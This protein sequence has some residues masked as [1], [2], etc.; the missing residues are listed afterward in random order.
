[1]SRTLI[2]SG[3]DWLGKIPINW[4][5]KPVKQ[6]LSERKELNTPITVTDILS[7]TNTRGVIPYS[8]K[9]DIG[10]KSKDDISGYKIVRKG[11]IV[12]NSMNLYIGSVGLSK[13]IGVVSPVYYMLYKRNP[14]DSIE[15]YNQLFQTKE[16]QT[17][18]HGYG[19]GILDIRMRIPMSN[20]NLLPLPVPPPE[21][22]HRIVSIL[23]NKVEQIDRLIKIQEQQIEKLKEYKQLIISN[24]VTK[25]LNIHTSLKESG[26]EWIGMI[27]THWEIR[28]L[29]SCIS[30]KLE[31]GANASGLTFDESL[32]RYIRITDITLDNELK[33]TEKLS[34]SEKDSSNYILY[35]GDV[36]FA[37]SGATVG[38][39]FLYK[40]EYGRSAYAGYLIRATVDKSV[41]S[42]EYLYYFTFSN[43][44]WEWA[45]GVFIQ[46]TIQNIG[47]NRYANMPLTV[48][49][50]D[51]QEKIVEKIKEFE[52]KI[53]LTLR[54]IKKKIEILNEY[55]KSLIYEYVTGKR[56]AI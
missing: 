35:D 12:I 15:Y 31:Y 54:L 53:K 26:I 29:K 18:S 48:P 34:L 56:E 14:K 10:N 40:K 39:S 52:S 27:P 33:D 16:L 45:K 37:R 20:L 22:Q 44:Y 17:K 23:N 28:R 4:Q 42:S 19:N 36:L 41:L 46:A 51:E 3:I 55:K 47:A 2:D 32:P 38:K 13:Y 8:E 11:D 30:R 24:L 7:L 49:P 25:G 5:V 9:G 1:M 43:E 50:L 6:V 21:E